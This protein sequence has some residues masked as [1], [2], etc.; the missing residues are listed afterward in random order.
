[1]PR[2]LIS[3]LVL[4]CYPQRRNF[5]LSG[6]PACDRLAYVHRKDPAQRPNDPALRRPCRRGLG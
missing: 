1:M 6:T 4:L 3:T 5:R 2:R